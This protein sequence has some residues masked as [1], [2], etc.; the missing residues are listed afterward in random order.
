[1]RTKILM[2]LLLIGIILATVVL[3]NCSKDKTNPSNGKVQ[4]I[5]TQPKDNDTIRGDT[6]VLIVAEADCADGIIAEVRFFVDGIGIGSSAK[7]PYKYEWHTDNEKSG[8]HTIKAEAKRN[9]GAS[10]TDEKKI[11]L[12]RGVTIAVAG[13]DTTTNDG[14][15]SL[16][17]FANEPEFDFETG[18]WTI[19][20]GTGGSFADPTKANTVFT[21]D[22]NITYLLRWTISNKYYSSSDEQKV[23]FK[24]IEY[25]TTITDYDG[26]TYK[27]VIIGNQ[28]WM[29]ENLKVTHQPNG[30]PIP[31]V[32]EMDEWMNLGYNNTDKA[33][34][35]YANSNANNDIYGALYTYAAAKDICPTGWH[36]PSDAE[37]TELKDFIFNDGN[38][39]QEGAALK[40]MTGWYNDGSGTDIYGFSALPGGRRDLK[41]TFEGLEKLGM[42]WSV[43]E[44]NSAGAYYWWLS[45][46]DPVLLHSDYV[47]SYGFS[48]RCVKD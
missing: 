41:G 35:Y 11:L 46:F 23:L 16:T 13:N 26:N 3:S 17:L 47:K 19:V 34:C 15:T 20:S 33:Y 14:S 4:C 9:D 40:S 25:G 10:G 27:T 7:F 44:Y 36:L 2:N 1:M 5:I 45:Y 21:G 29:A 31:L 28:T 38:S 12:I 22:L 18:K 43:T 42:W 32:T 30:T 39:G 6:S 8:L 37:W 24:K 48:V